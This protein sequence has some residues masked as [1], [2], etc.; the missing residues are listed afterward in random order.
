MTDPHTAA[1]RLLAQKI[2]EAIVREVSEL[3]DRDSPEGEPQTLLVNADEL[4][5]IV[6]AHITPS[7]EAFLRMEAALNDM[8]RMGN[9]AGIAWIVEDCEAALSPR[10]PQADGETM[11]TNNESD[12][13]IA[14]KIPATPPAAS[15]ADHADATTHAEAI[16]ECARLNRDW[17][18]HFEKD[19]NL[20]RC[21]L[22]L[23]AQ[24]ARAEA[25]RESYKAIAAGRYSQAKEYLERA[26]EAERKLARLEA[27]LRLWV[28][29]G[30]LHEKF[31]CPEDDTCTCEVAAAVNAALKSKAGEG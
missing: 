16:A 12:A 8:H 9:Q 7:C 4:N 15:A 23:T 10:T 1:V 27:A 20:A 3:P 2:S 17:R 29:R 13:W 26:V 11:P 25:E 5:A 19:A 24:L 14:S 6:E 28:D 31:G 18:Q 30:E 21:Y 22:A